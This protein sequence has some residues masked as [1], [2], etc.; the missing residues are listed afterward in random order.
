MK[1]KYLLIAAT[2]ICSTGNINAQAPNWLW[3]KG[4][5]GTS[6]DQ[7]QSIAVDASGNVY[8]TG[9]FQGTADFNP[10]AGVFNLTGGGMFISKLNSSGIFVWAKAIGSANG[11]S[12]V[13][14]A[15]G[16]VYT[17]GSFGG[18]VD[19]DP[20]AGVFN[21]TSSGGSQDIFIS[22]LDSSGNFVWA[23]AI[24]GTNDDRGCSL[25]LDSLDN[26]YTT[27]Y[28]TGTADFDPDSTVIFNLTGG[29]M[30]ISKLNSSG[31][32]VW[33]KAIG[34]ANG[35]SI[36]IDASGNV[37]TTGHFVGTVDFDPGAGTYNLTATVGGGLGDIFISK[38]DNSGNFVWAKGIGGY[39][40][41]YGLSIA[42]DASANVYTTGWFSATADFDPG[43]GIFNL[44]VVGGSSDIF[45]SKLD[46][47]GNFVWAKQIGGS[48]YNNGGW[49]IAL[50]AL[51]NV[52][53]TGHFGGT[54]DFDPGAG[55]FN[56]TVGGVFIS[57]LDS[58]G[59][60]VWAKAT[61]ATGYDRG[62]SI[63]LNF[64]GNV[65]ATGFFTGLTITFN[66]ITLT[67][68]GSSWSDVFIAKIDTMTTGIESLESNNGIS[69]YPNP[70]NGKFTVEM[71]GKLKQAEFDISI[72]NV[73]G[74]KVY[75]T[76]VNPSTGASNINL[77]VPGGIYFVQMS[78]NN[79]TVNQKIIIQ[80]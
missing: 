62:Q 69:V 12:I 25:T 14:D 39:N 35:N 47:S 63:A 75:S 32:F 16:N 40:D 50:D 71:D 13:T 79:Q 28:F 33:A 65:Y 24:G 11:Y 44:T 70:S 5:G 17:T 41:D 68:S 72:Y 43:T 57:K 64:S 53:T 15:S 60:F 1:K 18:T 54:V 9:Y 52:Y 67:N 36:V 59:N 42:L 76:I 78:N 37:Y 10:G 58:S 8:T 46:S 61:G 34:S 66:S 2:F 30:F 48:T 20:G 22:K 3:A 73:L 21:L 23:K 29:G 51:G 31:N 74:E 56:L 38:L 77:D 19:F 80:K 6:D 49:S 26:V 4:M 27:G 7:G 55:V 45:I